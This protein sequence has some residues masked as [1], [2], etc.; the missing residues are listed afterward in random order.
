MPAV[1]NKI[2]NPTKNSLPENVRETVIGLL[3]GS[4]AD[5]ADLQFQAKTA[6]WNVKGANF[7]ALHELFDQAHAETIAWTDTI[8]E[9]LVM[10]GGVAEGNVQAVAKNTRLPEYS[11]QIK[12]SSA[13][14]EAFSTALAAYGKTIRNNIDK[15]DEAGDKDTADLFTGISRAVD[16]MLWFVESHNQ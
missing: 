10:L 4:L 14:V 7:I 2:A 15:A 6:H 16:K 5:S 13:H 3:Q 12:E 8:A 1:A 11:L 9:R